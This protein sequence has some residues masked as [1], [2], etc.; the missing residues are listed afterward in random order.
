MGSPLLIGTQDDGAA[1][2]HVPGGE[3]RQ[4]SVL[5]CY[6]KPCATLP[7]CPVSFLPTELCVCH[8]ALHILA[9]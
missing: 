8:A 1:L 2:P 6:M 5:Q 7:S 9:S 3:A 4:Q